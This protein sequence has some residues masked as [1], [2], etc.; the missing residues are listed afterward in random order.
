MKP[1]ARSLA[2]AYAA[3]EVAWNIVGS[4]ALVMLSDVDIDEWN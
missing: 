4:N 2:Q 3:P 1:V